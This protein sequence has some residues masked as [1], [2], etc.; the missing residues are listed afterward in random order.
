M[1]GKGLGK[2]FATHIY[3]ERFVTS[4]YKEYLQINYKSSREN[5]Q[6]TWTSFKKENIP[7]GGKHEAYSTSLIIRAKTTMRYQGDKYSLDLFKLKCFKLNVSEDMDKL[8]LLHN[9][10]GKDKLWKAVCHYLL[11]LVY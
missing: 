8:G 11:M 9:T 5:V 1:K 4:V 6:N 2:L 7:I 10:G 3:N